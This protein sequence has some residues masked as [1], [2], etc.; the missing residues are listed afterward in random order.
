MANETA[1]RDQ[2]DI[3]VLMGITDDSNQEIRMLRVNPTTGRLLITGLVSAT[4]YQDEVVSYTNGTNYTLA[5]APTTVLFL[6]LNGQHLVNTVDYTYSGVN[7]TM[8]SSTLSTDVLS[9]T[10]S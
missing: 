3:P 10:Y 1:K 2:N 8:L 5:H 4:W 6:F 9:A 7:I